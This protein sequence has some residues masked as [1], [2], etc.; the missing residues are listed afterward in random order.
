MKYNLKNNNIGILILSY[1][2]LKTLKEVVKQIKKNISKEDFIYIFADGINKKKTFKEQKEASQVL[3]YL[4]NTKDKKLVIY[5]QQK[6]IGLK[7][8]WESAYESMFKKFN[9]VISLQDDDVIKKGFIK[10][11]IYYLNKYENNKKVM[12][13]TGFATKISLEPNYNFDSY[14]TKRS[15]SYSQASWRRVWR[16]YKRLNKNPGN[17]IKSQ[18][19]RELLNAAGTDLLP[20]MTLAKLKLIDSIQIWWSWNIIKNNGVCLNPVASLVENKG[21]LDDKATHSYK[22]KFPQNTY[23][24][25]YNKH[26]KKLEKIIYYQKID[27]LFQSNYKTSKFSYFIFNFFPLFFIQ[28]LYNIKA[29]YF[30]FFTFFKTRLNNK[31]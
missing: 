12:N 2:R 7:N 17:I 25:K 9:K 31:A 29:T 15:M 1:R 8:N 20:L 26:N 10:Y 28:F 16:S 6:N 3:N 14:F 19:N 5:F 18:K 13:I 27:L 11:M 23:N 30:N 4:K 22:N 24:N 21:F